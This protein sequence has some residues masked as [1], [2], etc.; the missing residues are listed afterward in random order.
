MHFPATSEVYELLIRPKLTSLYD[1]GACVN[2]EGL[3][4]V[5]AQKEL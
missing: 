1:D 3:F 2:I 4:V 5:D